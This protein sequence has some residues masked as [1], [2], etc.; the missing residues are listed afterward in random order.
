[1]VWDDGLKKCITVSSTCKDEV[2]TSTSAGPSTTTTK[3]PQSSTPN[4]PDVTTPQ[5]PLT[6][7]VHGPTKTTNT[8]Q[9]STHLI[10]DAT[11]PSPSATTSV[12]EPSESTKSPQPSTSNIPDVT[13]RLTE[14]SKSTLRPETSTAV[15]DTTKEIIFYVDI[16]N[17][18]RKASH[19]CITS[20]ESLPDGDYQSCLSCQVY[21]SCF[22]G[23][24]IDNRPCPAGL[25]WDNEK[26]ECVLESST[27]EGQTPST[28]TSPSEPDI[29]DKPTTAGA[30]TPRPPHVELTTAT[31]QKDLKL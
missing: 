18:I 8:P 31:S 22:G 20:C 6:T 28:P 15:R 25:S 4:V 24:F 23:Q 5:P 17:S 29:S 9:T 21:A 11:T 3:V 26:K 7:R 27:C 16:G 30:S 1:M 14:S 2:S 19:S 10:P 12:H 13:S